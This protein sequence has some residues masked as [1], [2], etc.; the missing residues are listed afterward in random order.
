[1][2]VPADLLWECVKDSSSFIRKCRNA[3]VM[4]AEPNN[5]C[6]LNSF[7][8]SGL[9]CQKPLDVT[10][11]TTGKKK[12]IMITKKPKHGKPSRPSSMSAGTGVKNATKKGIEVITKETDGAFYRKDLKDLAVKKYLKIKK[13]FRKNKNLPKLRKAKATSS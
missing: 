8:Y 2:R 5:L 4:T 6:G 13:S 10:I 7:K 11:Q 1:M 3:P 9:A 12:T